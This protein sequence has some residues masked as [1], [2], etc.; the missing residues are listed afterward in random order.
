MTIKSGQEACCPETVS[1]L[2]NRVSDLLLYS[3]GHIE[4]QA[5]PHLPQCGRNTGLRRDSWI[6]Q[7]TVKVGQTDEAKGTKDGSQ[8]ES[9]KKPRVSG[10]PMGGLLNVSTCV[11]LE[12]RR[13][14]SSASVYGGDIRALTR[15][16][17][18][19]RCSKCVQW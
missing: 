19:S 4:A 14:I 6:S 2:L 1:L 17:V 5:W 18:E 15:V 10:E 3:Q 9:E 8:E 13:N 16:V 12:G 11:A 7:D